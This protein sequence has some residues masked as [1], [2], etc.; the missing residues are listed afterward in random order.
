MTSIDRQRK[1]LGGCAWGL[2]LGLTISSGA[3]AATPDLTNMSIEELAQ[4]EVISVSKSALPLSDAPAAIYAITHDEILRSGATSLP[5]MLRLAPNL[6]VAQITASRYAVS[7]R[8]FNSGVADKLLAL[9]DGRSIYTPFSSGVNWHLQDVAPDD[10]ERI[11]VVSGPGG[12]LWGANAVNGVINI[13]TRKSGDTQG[14]A[15]EAAGGNSEFR[16]RLRYGG[17]ISDDLTYRVYVGGFDHRDMNLTG[18]GEKAHDAW[19]KVQGGF[20]MDWAPAADL[21]TVQGDAF[22]GTEQQ[23]G[24]PDQAMS[25]RNL[26]ARWTHPLGAKSNLQVQAYYDHV[27]FLVPDYFSNYLDTYDIQAQHDFSLGSHA[28]VWGGGY[29]VMHDDFPTTLSSVQGVSFVPRSRTLTLWNLFLQDSLPLTARLTLIAGVKLE[30]EP[31][32][33]L[34]IMPNARLS[35]A[36]TDSSL[37][38]FAASR[39]VR[40]PSRLDRDA[41]QYF[42]SFLVLTGGD[43][44][45]IKVTAYELG[46]RAQPLPGLSF[47]LSTFYNVYP[48]LRSAEYTH[49]TYPITFE[50]GME[51]E[52]YG[53]E[54][55]VNYSAT[56]WWRLSAGANRLYKDLRF[57]PYSDQLGGLQIAGDDPKYQLSLRSAMDLGRGFAL[58]MDFR[59]VGALPAPPSPAYTELNARLAWAATER[60]EISM[61]G[62]NLLHKYHNE[63]STEINTL[64]V[65]PL[66]VRIR[67]SVSLAAHWKI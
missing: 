51:G 26:L 44:Q 52:T 41:S 19:H 20:R 53:V 29:R 61:I 54:F 7:A 35:W 31:Y 3:K 63:F 27:Q 13:I 23:L 12:T 16:G 2:A 33:G 36:V 43:M 38:W 28:F 5:E 50:N 6:Q 24:G 10:I 15:M 66:G 49:G 4:I 47:S 8:G 60:F 9:V 30:H 67:R 59:R 62:S 21:V 37:L 34:A 25:G 40:I 1:L 55:W 64:Q 46:Y 45:A 22:G 39:A 18:A 11:E 56:P 17:R 57:K 14:A 42:G 32:T 65:G 48:N 58:D